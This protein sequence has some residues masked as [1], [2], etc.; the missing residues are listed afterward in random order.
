MEEGLG[1]RVGPGARE[2]AQVG[3][4]KPVA[5]ERQG[6][7]RPARRPAGSVGRVRRCP[8][9]RRPAQG[10]TQLSGV[11]TRARRAARCRSQA[12]AKSATRSRRPSSGPAWLRR[13]ASI[14]SPP[15]ARVDGIEGRADPS[16]DDRGGRETR[17][18]I[19]VLGSSDRACRARAWRPARTRH[20]DLGAVER[21][22]AAGAPGAM[23]SRWL[24]RCSVPD[25]GAVRPATPMAMPVR[26]IRPASSASIA[27]SLARRLAAPAR[28]AS[29][30]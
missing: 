23:S 14:R 25:S 29:A 13:H 18:L 26:V 5:H 3:D 4:G 9:R 16:L 15:A 30:P 1:E 2:Q 24:S 27:G 8:R 19:E 12:R 7:E 28:R 20:P 21:E 22:G 11:A 6:P 10:V 17:V